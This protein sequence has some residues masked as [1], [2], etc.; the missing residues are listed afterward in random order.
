[1]KPMTLAAVCSITLLASTVSAAPSFE[2]ID[3][4]ASDTAFLTI[5]EAATER[6]QKLQAD[7]APG[8]AQSWQVD[9]NLDAL[10][11]IEGQDGQR[12]N[13]RRGAP[14]S[15]HHL[16]LDIP[17]RGMPLRLRFDTVYEGFGGVITYAGIIEGDEG[18]LVAI[19]VDGDEILGK[20]HHSE[21]YTYLIER[22]RSSSHYTLSV[23][24]QTLI[25]RVRKSHDT[26][27]V[28]EHTGHAGLTI[29]N[30][31]EKVETFTPMS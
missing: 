9:L 21:G 15:G 5:Q 8:A 25:P 7:L 20:I 31:Q 22:D 1:M 26:A 12:A 11:R 6:A 28:A 18:S 27:T 4:T 30:P 17:E 2:R 3:R 24:D 16:D 29:S 23:I 19:S 13:A 14:L 10:T